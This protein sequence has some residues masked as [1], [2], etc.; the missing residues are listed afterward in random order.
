MSVAL[1]SLRA[2]IDNSSRTTVRQLSAELFMEGPEA[3]AYQFF[4]RFYSNYG[5]LPSIE[6]MREN[7]HML[8]AA[9]GPLHYFLQRL[10]DRAIF[11]TM[12]AALPEIQ[13]AMQT[14]NVEEAVALWSA[15]NADMRFFS[16]GEDTVPIIGLM[17]EVMEQHAQARLTPDNGLVGVT[18]GWPT[19]DRLTG[20]LQPQDV[21]SVVARPNVGKSWTLIHMAK[22]AWLAGTSI[23]FVTMEMSAHQIARRTL[24]LA[25]GI[26]P[27]NIRRG[28]LTMHSE[29]ILHEWIEAAGD[30]PPFHLMSGAFK[31]TTTDIDRAIQEFGPDACYIDASY[32]VG[33]EKKQ[34]SNGSR[35]ERIY[36]VGEEI[37][38]IANDRE[39]PVV[40]SLQANREKKKGVENDMT[41]IAGGDVIGQISSGVLFVEHGEGDF[42]STQR[43]YELG[44][45]REGGLG[46]FTTNFLFN[47][48]NFNE[49]TEDDENETLLRLQANI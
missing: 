2:I 6:I 43:R 15:A 5:A 21:F 28:R 41:Q 3:N 36:D 7:G 17:R 25:S 49:I 37:K 13:Q 38:G 14:R 46:K 45:N 34:R 32:L 20:G 19:L 40:Q 12:Q 11:A 33:S 9:P 44:K 42:E 48:M 47:P 23:V 8:P 26:N 16:G 10:R 27:D 4:S 29:D 22:E 18:T 24:S 31:K 1:Q 35:W 39:I 30:L